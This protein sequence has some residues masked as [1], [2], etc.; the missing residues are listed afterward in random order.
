M[1]NPFDRADYWANVRRRWIESARN[2]SSVPRAYAL[3]KA[4]E[5]EQM[6]GFWIRR[7]QSILMP[8]GLP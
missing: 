1:P 8:G 5:A 3:M 7:A 6:V 4:D 2:L